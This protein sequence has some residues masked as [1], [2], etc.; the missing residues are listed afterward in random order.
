MGKA[1]SH[2]L[3]KVVDEIAAR[4]EGMV[5]MGRV[6]SHIGILGNGAADVMAKRGYLWMIMNN[7][8][9][10]EEFGSGHSSRRRRA[11]RGGGEGNQEG[12]GVE[13]ES[14]NEL[15]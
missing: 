6:K 12:D 4:G 14:S 7:G 3:K 2:H 1:R 9:P 15:L 11:W 8:C 5:N 13:E 10:G